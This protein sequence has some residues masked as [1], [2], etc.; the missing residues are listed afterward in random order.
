MTVECTGRMV[1]VLFRRQQAGF[2]RGMQRQLICVLRGFWEAKL[3]RLN[4][5]G[6]GIALRINV[7]RP[8]PLG[9]EVVEDVH[10]FV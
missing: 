8:L 4:T 10:N 7:G 3:D 1:D 6:K 5:L 2:R 9:V